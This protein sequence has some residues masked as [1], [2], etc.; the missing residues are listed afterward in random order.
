MKLSRRKFLVSGS[1]SLAGT[2]FLPNN[3]LA[4]K[5]AR[6]ISV[7]I[8]L[9]SVRDDMKKDPLG[10]LKQLAAM[11]YRNVEHANYTGKKFY[12]YTATEFKKILNGLGLKMPSGHTVMSDKHWDKAT[13]DFT[14]EW[15]QTVEDAATVGQRYVI[16]PWLDES[17][18]KDYDGLVSFLEVFNKCGELCKKSGLKFGYHNHDF[19]FSNSLNDKMIYDIILEKT[20]PALVT[21]Q[22]DIG[23]MHGGGGRPLEL[24]KKYPG[25]F[26]SM[27]VKDEIE[28]EKKEGVSNKYES[29]IL[30][31]GIVPVKEVVDLARKSGGTTEFII[32]Q[33]SYQGKTPLECSKEDLKIMKSWGY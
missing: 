1:L 3:I 29:T 31:K 18:R 15:K 10:T 13:K 17:L 19:E 5:S 25:R 11:G 9:Y 33:E 2:M 28:T 14:D 6:E 7:G 30:G 24:L 4:N 8:Q 23:N 26:E 16:S 12:G 20:D 21:Q 27:H 22:M 32:E